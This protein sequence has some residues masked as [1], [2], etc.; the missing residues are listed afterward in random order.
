MRCHQPKESLVFGS[1]VQ[2]TKTAWIKRQKKMFVQFLGCWADKI[3]CHHINPC[4]TQLWQLRK[5]CSNF[6]VVSKFYNAASIS[7]LASKFYLFVIIETWKY[8]FW[9]VYLFYIEINKNKFFKTLKKKKDKTN[10]RKYVF[11][12]VY[13]FSDMSFNIITIKYDY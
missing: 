9:D 2:W 8:C 6:C 5:S 7:M 10:E 13:I 4:Y 1:H 12:I 3:A 11:F